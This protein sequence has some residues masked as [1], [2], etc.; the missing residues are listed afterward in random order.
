M[1]EQ[2]ATFSYPVS[3]TPCGWRRGGGRQRLLTMIDFSS[4]PEVSV[5][6][7]WGLKA[8]NRRMM[9]LFLNL[10]VIGAIRAMA[11]NSASSICQR[12]RGDVRGMMLNSSLLAISSAGLLSLPPLSVQ[13]ANSVAALWSISKLQQSPS[14]QKNQDRRF[15]GLIV[16][17]IMSY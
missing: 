12:R 7:I 14:R 5:Y 13:R 9:F 1:C 2:T 8:E 3:A 4:L 16:S 17:T 6:P 10:S 15:S 11:L